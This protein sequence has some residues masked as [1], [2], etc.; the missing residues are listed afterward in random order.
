M[1]AHYYCVHCGT[2]YGKDHLK[3]PRCGSYE[4]R[5]WNR[6]FTPRKTEGNDELK[7][8]ASTHQSNTRDV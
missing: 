1:A 7:L 8:A 4:A 5:L 6:A 2:L 3:C